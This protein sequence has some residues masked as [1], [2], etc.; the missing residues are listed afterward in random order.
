M[1]ALNPHLGYET[2]A[3][4]ANEAIATGKSVRELC[5]L[6]NVLSEE[7]LDLILNP[8]QMTEP[9]IAGKERLEYS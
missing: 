5:L 7:E 6:Y 3:R 4:I 9:G 8:Y 2:A 1:T